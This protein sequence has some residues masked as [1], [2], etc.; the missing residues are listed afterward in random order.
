MIDDWGISVEIFLRWMP[1]DLTDV[2]LTWFAQ[3]FGIIR[4]QANTSA[5]VDPDLWREIESL[6]HKDIRYLSHGIMTSWNGNSFRITDTF[7]VRTL[8]WRNNERDSVSNHQLHD[9]LLNR[10]SRRRSKK[11]STLCVT[12]LCDGNSP[13]P[14]YSPHRGPVTRKTFHLMTSSWNDTIPSGGRISTVYW[15]VLL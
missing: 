6:G 11:T 14:G 2:T 4:Q 8:H 12:G 15:V 9:C 7:S 5:N 3:W 10:S 13:G 1:F